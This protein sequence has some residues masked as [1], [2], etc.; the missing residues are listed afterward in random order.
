MASDVA[1]ASRY[2]SDNQFPSF[3]SFIANFVDTNLRDYRLVA[4]SPFIDAG[5]DGKDLGCAF[6]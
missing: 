4:S 6:E 2:P 3:A 5:L 1:V